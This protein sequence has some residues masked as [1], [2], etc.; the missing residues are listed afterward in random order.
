MAYQDSVLNRLISATMREIELCGSMSALVST[1]P[2]ENQTVF[3]SFKETLSCEF[4][5]EEIKE[6]QKYLF[7]TFCSDPIEFQE[8]ELAIKA[9]QKEFK[10][11]RILKCPKCD[12]SHPSLTTVRDFDSKGFYISDADLD[13]AIAL[14]TIADLRCRDFVKTGVW[15]DAKDIDL[16]K[17]HLVTLKGTSGITEANNFDF[18]AF[19][20][21]YPIKDLVNGERFFNCEYE[22]TAEPDLLSTPVGDWAENV[23]SVLDYKR[24]VDKVSAFTQMSAI[25]KHYGLKQMVAIPVNGETAQGFSKPVVSKDIDG[26]FEVFLDKRRKFRKRY[27][28]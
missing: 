2:F 14:G 6:K 27:N 26:Y 21:K 25:A 19:L 23:P 20:K 12:K 13:I 10:H 8:R 7:K 5:D 3:L 17:P 15:K 1:G 4:T 28:I 22:F 11:L 18:P 9:I 16:C 24:N